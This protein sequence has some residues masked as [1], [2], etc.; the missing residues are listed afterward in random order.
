MSDQVY[1]PPKSDIRTPS[2]EAAQIK[3]YSPTQVGLGAFFGGP[4]AAIYFL[5]G[6]FDALQEFEFSRRVAIIGAV[7]CVVMLAVIPFLPDNVPNN[8]FPLFYLIPTVLTVKKYHPTKKEIQAS[9]R[10]SF[11]SSWKV[12]G[13]SIMWTFVFFF[14]SLAVALGYEALGFIRL[15]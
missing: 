10:Y 11:Q 7:A 13:L 9:E 5:K 6:N 15:D 1:A 8:L 2:D 12:L 14:V 3:L 4:F